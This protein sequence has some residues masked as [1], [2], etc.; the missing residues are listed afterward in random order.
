M[1]CGVAYRLGL[2][3]TLLWLWHRPAAVALIQPL[4]WEFPYA[5]DKALKKRP[6]KEKKAQLGPG[7]GIPCRQTYAELG[8]SLKCIGKQIECLKEQKGLTLIYVFKSK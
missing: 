6:K 7:C 8:F 2:D 3:P 4:A 1:S 5:T